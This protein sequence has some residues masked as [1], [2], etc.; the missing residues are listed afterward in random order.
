[1]CHHRLPSF[2]AC[3]SKRTGS[4]KPNEKPLFTEDAALLL[5]AAQVFTLAKGVRGRCPFPSAHWLFG[6]IAMP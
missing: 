5:D 1:M 4:D 2:A 6:I 3:E